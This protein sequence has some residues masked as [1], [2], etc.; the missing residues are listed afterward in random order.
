[1]LLN[2]DCDLQTNIPQNDPTTI[3]LSNDYYT[4]SNRALNI[5]ENL[6]VEYSIGGRWVN[7]S[8][9]IGCNEL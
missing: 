5:K 4:S 3:Y 7:D 6:K 9:S 8:T 2:V 1:M